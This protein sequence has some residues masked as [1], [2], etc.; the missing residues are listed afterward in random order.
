MNATNPEPGGRMDRLLREV[1]RQ[2]AESVDHPI[3]P[4]ASRTFLWREVLHGLTGSSPVLMGRSARGAALAL[5]AAMLLAAAGSA[6]IE[7][8]AWTTPDLYSGR[9]VAWFF[10]PAG[11]VNGD[12]FSDL[13]VG[14]P[15]VAE[16]NPGPGH[17]E[18]YHGSLNGFSTE[19]AD[20]S[21]S[22]GSTGDQFGVNVAAAGDV[23]GD[24]FDD[25]V[26]GAIHAELGSGKIYVYAGGPDGLSATPSWTATG[27]G[28][29]Y[30]DLSG[31]STAG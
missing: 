13:I 24:G 29:G 8:P 7:A 9:N 15:E 16:E 3:E 6:S 31:L 10:A 25:I 30:V 17:V 20:W 11:D 21:A 23:D 19:H 26:V 18:A 12:G 27:S 5:T 22:E 14:I 4:L 2:E 1:V 28:G